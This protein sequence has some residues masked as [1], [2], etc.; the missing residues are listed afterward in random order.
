[1]GGLF[2]HGCMQTTAPFSVLQEEGALPFE[3]SMRLVKHHNKLQNT[4]ACLWAGGTSTEPCKLPEKKPL[5]TPAL[6]ANDCLI[7]AMYTRGR[8][9][10]GNGSR[11]LSQLPGGFAECPVR[12]EH[13]RRCATE[14]V[15][16][17]TA[18]PL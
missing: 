7:M 12:W 18:T 2:K 13:T 3:S 5:G 14:R 6:V 9:P 11:G 1:M 8:V 10:T 4:R 16:P 15:S 17:N